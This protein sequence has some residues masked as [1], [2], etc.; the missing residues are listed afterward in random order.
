MLTRLIALVLPILLLAGAASAN[1]RLLSGEVFYR[2]RMALP[3]GSTLYVGLVTL[4]E[5]RPVVGAGAAIPRGGQ[6]PLKFSLAIRSEVASSGEAFGLVAE[7][8]NGDSVLFRNVVAAPVDL[9]AAAPIQILVT[10]QPVDDTPPEP[11]ID[12]NLVGAIWKVTS[13]SG[14]PVS[15]ARPVTLSIAPDLR[16]GGHAGCN[17]YFTQAVVDGSAVTFGTAA[18]TRKA[19]TPDLMA[20]ETGYFAALAAVTAYEISAD[21]LRL[22]DAA[23]VPLVGLVRTS[24]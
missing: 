16:A 20:Q 7:I 14:S 22:L 24:E 15:G 8:R 19:C 17:D 10:R 6:V 1:E 18:A 4:P 23:G 5:G 2:E 12:Q 21:S 13:I 11:K 3:A 9:G